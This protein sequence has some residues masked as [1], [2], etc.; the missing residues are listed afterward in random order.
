MRR[1]LCSLL[2]V[3][4][5][6]QSGT[7][8]RGERRSRL[9]DARDGKPEAG[10]RRGE[11]RSGREFRPKRLSRFRGVDTTVILPG[12][13]RARWVFLHVGSALMALGWHICRCSVL[14][15]GFV[16]YWYEEYGGSW[17][18]IL[19][20][21]EGPVY[22]IRLACGGGLVRCRV[23]KRHIIAGGLAPRLFVPRSRATGMCWRVVHWP[24]SHVGMTLGE[25][26]RVPVCVTH[27]FGNRSSAL[28]PW[29]VAR[30]SVPYGA[31]CVD[32]DTVALGCYLLTWRDFA[33][34]GSW[35]RVATADGLVN[36]VVSMT[37]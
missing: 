16:M 34:R 25:M 7:G 18:K 1:L 6:Q 22:F 4:Q 26:R 37:S 11:G 19:G 20:A 17:V 33:F 14:P 9:H 2:L 12:L 15:E 35:G 3:T 28:A 32:A 30:C 36:A 21:P 27:A 8:T 13:R 10:G 24:C 5:V 23:N 31:A 29:V